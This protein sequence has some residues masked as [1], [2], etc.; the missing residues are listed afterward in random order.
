MSKAAPMPNII[1]SN[2]KNKMEH[3][4]LLGLTTTAKSDWRGKVEELKKFGIKRIAFFPTF[5]EFE[6]R[7]ELYNL[8]ETVDGLEIPHVHLRGDMDPGELDY[9][10]AR[11]KSKVFNLHAINKN[12]IKNDFS[13]FKEMIYIE[14]NRQVTPAQSEL[15]AYAGICV[16]FS[17]L[18]NSRFQNI[19]QYRE[20]MKLISKNK[21]GC[22]HVSAVKTH[23]WNPFNWKHGFDRHTLSSM[24]ELDYMVKY[25]KYLPEYVSLELENN[26]EKQLEVK[27]YLEKILNI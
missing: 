18:E 6:E 2:T 20:V 21:I 19:F 23:K 26:L 8:L 11:Y 4:I 10:V 12:P 3:E 13:Q 14:N 9:F 24:K 22:A 1:L 17:H 5:L 27:A 16:D 25:K 15:D 7:K